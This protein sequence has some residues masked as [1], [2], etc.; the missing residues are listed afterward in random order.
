MCLELQKECMRSANC[1]NL[2]KVLHKKK[3]KKK[4]KKFIY[5]TNWFRLADLVQRMGFSVLAVNKKLK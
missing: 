3:K 1:L 4:I 2:F 5:L